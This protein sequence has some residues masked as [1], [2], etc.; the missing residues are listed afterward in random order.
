MTAVDDILARIDPQQLADALG[1]DQATARNAAKA[2]IPTLLGSLQANTQTADGEASLLK[3]LDQHVDTVFGDSV[4]L[5]AVDTNDGRRIVQHA[6][7]D[8]PQR[9]QGLGG[10]G[11]G[12]IAKLLPLL[13]PIV[14][15]YLAQKLSGATA[16]TSSTTTGTTAPAGSGDALGDLLG[17]LLGGGSTPSSAGGLGGILGQ[18]LG[19]A[20]ATTSTKQGS[21]TGSGTRPSG[22]ALTDLLGK[23][24][25]R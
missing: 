17:G 6:I 13:A 3:A 24:L 21:G 10:F 18:V 12:L 1:T 8:D 20:T 14:M 4:D 23:I 15:S 11:D 25:G 19:G 9:L 2:A 22:D 5:T 7:A 16:S